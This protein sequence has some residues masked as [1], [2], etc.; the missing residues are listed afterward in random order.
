MSLA[1]TLKTPV[2]NISIRA[3]FLAAPLVHA[4]GRLPI[5]QM[6]SNAQSRCAVL[7]AKA[8]PV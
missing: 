1:F 7:V 2:E 6:F 3:F 4:L 8:A 5:K